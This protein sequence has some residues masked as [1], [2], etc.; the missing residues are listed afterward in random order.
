MNFLKHFI[1]FNRN[2]CLNL[3][4]LF[5]RFFLAGENYSLDLKR[6]LDKAIVDFKPERV[7]EV[8][9]IDRPLLKKTSS[10]HYIGMDIESNNNCYQF[11]DEFVVQSVE[12]SINDNVQLVF[13]TTLLEHV[14]DNKK[15]LLNIYNA[16][17]ENGLTY[18][19]VP[20]KN[21]PYSLALRLVGP[22]LQ[23]ILIKHLRPHA[24]DVTGYPAFF[25]LCT[26][27]QMKN[28]MVKI[29]F[30][31]VNVTAYYKATDYFSF[32]VPAYLLVAFFE[33]IFKFFGVSVLASGFII[34]AE[35]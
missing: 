28:E 9:G 11:Y 13:S 33:N 24:A 31:N 17:S 29:G 19:Y 1:S 15:S 16:L 4:R 3:N 8:G 6:H 20:S 26:P 30:K 14:K 34:A 27:L 32:F 25:N 12:D 5:P 22:K 23:K 2:V 7:L 21:H 10:F 18:H 35:K